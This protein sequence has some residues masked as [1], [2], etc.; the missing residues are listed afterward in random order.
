[1]T[2]NIRLRTICAIWETIPPGVITS[3]NLWSRDILYKYQGAQVVFKMSLS[4]LLVS[5]LQ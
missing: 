4:Q 5:R 3:E 2:L 1:M